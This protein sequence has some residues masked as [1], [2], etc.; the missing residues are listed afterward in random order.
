MGGRDRLCRVYIGYV[1]TRTIVLR[2]VGTHNKVTMGRYMI[3]SGSEVATPLCGEQTV[4]SRVDFRMC[5]YKTCCSGGPCIWGLRVC[6]RHLEILHNI[7]FKFM[8]CT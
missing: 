1:R 4:V 7:S 8:F 2:T 5:N 6:S 3:K